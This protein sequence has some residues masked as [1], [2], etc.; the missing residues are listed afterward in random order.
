MLI[1]KT[2]IESVIPQR[3]PFV[4]IDSLESA[5]WTELKGLFQVRP[6]NI[7]LRNEVLTEPAL[8][9]NIAQTCAAGFG[10]M[11]RNEG[12]AGKIG[13]IGGISKLEIHGLPVIGDVIQSRVLVTYKLDNIYVVKG[14]S[15]C[16]D[17][18][19]IECEMKIVLG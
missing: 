4:M 14:E 1:D 19:L 11:A 10:F 16:R 3:P 17:Q 6:D 13:F 18:K 5:D 7:F 9:E 2:N 15:I 12:G 8:V